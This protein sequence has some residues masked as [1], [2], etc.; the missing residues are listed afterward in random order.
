FDW[1]P[2][3]PTLGDILDLTLVGIEEESKILN[4][5][6]WIIPLA[7]GRFRAGSTYHGC[8]SDASIEERKEEVLERVRGITE[9]TPVVHSQRSGLRPIIRRSQIF[10][11]RH[12]TRPQVAFFNGLGSKGVLNGPWYAD[13]LVSHLVDQSPL[14]DESDLL[15]NRV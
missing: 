6:G 7:N 9:A 14:P 8:N 3:K 1:V 2:M 4:K 15:Q 11:G 10:A 13:R 12:P 5:G